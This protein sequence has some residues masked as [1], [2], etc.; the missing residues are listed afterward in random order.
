MGRRVVVFL[1]G[2]YRPKPNELARPNVDKFLGALTGA[3]KKLGHE[4]K[5]ID[6]FL[7]T[8]A[9]SIDA[10]GSIDDP[11]IGVYA[12]WVYGPHSCWRRISTARGPVSSGCS[13]PARA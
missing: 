13:I 5:L 8:P 7:T 6:K 4:P 9:D 10:L 1:P 3:L 11:M 12:H 2:D